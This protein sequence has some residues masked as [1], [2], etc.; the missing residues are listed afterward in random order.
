MYVF[1]CCCSVFHVEF[2]FPIYANR[3]LLNFI[4]AALLE[5]TEALVSDRLVMDFMNKSFLI[6]QN[7]YAHKLLNDMKKI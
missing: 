6:T 2:A 3:T 5:E 7:C 1:N 4:T